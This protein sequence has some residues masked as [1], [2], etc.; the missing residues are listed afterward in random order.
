MHK[1][2]KFLIAFTFIGLILNFIYPGEADSIVFLGLTFLSLFYF[3][4]SFIILNIDRT[5]PFYKRSSYIGIS[6]QQIVISVLS[7]FAY[8]FVLMGILFRLFKLPGSL[9]ELVVGLSILTITLAL[10]I[11]FKGKKMIQEGFIMNLAW[12]SIPAFLLGVYFLVEHL[13]RV[14]S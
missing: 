2:E 14:Y 4:F 1:F 13:F 6:K 3:L 11:V 7:G 12:R 8:A 5:Q 9:E 10:L